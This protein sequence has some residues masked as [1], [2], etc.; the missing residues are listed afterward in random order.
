MNIIKKNKKNTK[1][2]VVAKSSSKAKIRRTKV[3]IDGI[4]FDSKMESNYYLKLKDDLANNRIKGFSLQ[5]EFIL[6]EKFIIVEG[7]V[8]YGSDKDFNKLKRKYKA[9]T[10]RQIKYTGDFLIE[11]L[12]G[13]FKVVE[14]KGLSTPEFEIRKKLFQC[15]YP[16]Y[17]LEILIYDDK[18]KTWI[19]Y[20]KHKKEKSSRKK[21]SSKK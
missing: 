6:Q 15:R 2:K 5:P 17:S 1:T 16:M 20:Y 12:D 21:K 14:T 11:E 9:E 10:V 7:R 19:D 13:S 3:E 8:V 18:S 4:V